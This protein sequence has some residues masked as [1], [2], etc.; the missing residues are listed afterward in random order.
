MI[1]TLSELSA[2]IRYATQKRVVLEVGFIKLC[3]PD[4]ADG[5][6]ALLAR[7]QRLE[8]NMAKGTAVQMSGILPSGQAG[9]K[10]TTDQGNGPG[11]GDGTDKNGQT[12]SVP[13]PNPDEDLKSR[14]SPADAED[15]RKIAASWNRLVGSLG[16]PMRRHLNQAK[17]AVAE[18]KDKLLLVFD[19]DNTLS[20]NAKLY[21]EKNNQ[22]NLDLLSDIVAKRT[23]K[24]TSFRCVMASPAEKKQAN[25]IDLTKIDFDHIEII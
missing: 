24:R 10:G 16:N 12:A 17:I 7:I 20:E 25:L 5:P 1:R 21:L 13:E 22:E 11:A 9:Q 4:M 23:G 2:E 19:P 8:E 14:F 15:I 6:E 18:D 3:L